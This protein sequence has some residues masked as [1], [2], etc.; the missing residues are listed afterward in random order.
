M[1]QQLPE[2]TVSYCVTFLFTG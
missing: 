1:L 2:Y